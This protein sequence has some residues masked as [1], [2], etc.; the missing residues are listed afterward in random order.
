M[1][2]SFAPMISGMAGM[3]IL[4]F[5]LPIVGAVS[6][7]LVYVGLLRR[8]FGALFVGIA[9][10]LVVFAVGSILRD[11]AINA[12]GMPAN[13]E[14]SLEPMTSMLPIGLLIAAA[15]FVVGILPGM[16]RATLR[17]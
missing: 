15:I 13:Y 4:I 2:V 7:G 9:F 5:L 12:P 1:A 14:A 8:R 11:N 17:H 3:Y 10:P 6:I 16:V